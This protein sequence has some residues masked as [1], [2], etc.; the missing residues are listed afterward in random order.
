MPQADQGRPMARANITDGDNPPPEMRPQ[1]S[2]KAPTMT[3]R[4]SPAKT[5]RDDRL[6]LHGRQD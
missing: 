4:L 1:I 2:T 6:T 3:N 5:G